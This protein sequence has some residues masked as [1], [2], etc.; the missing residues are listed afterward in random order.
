MFPLSDVEPYGELLTR[1]GEQPSRKHD[2]RH[3]Y[4]SYHGT[5]TAKK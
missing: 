2:R 4:F 3:V 1:F 5:I